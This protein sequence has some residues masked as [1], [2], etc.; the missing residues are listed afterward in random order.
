MNKTLLFKL[1]NYEECLFNTFVEKRKMFVN[2][3]SE[4]NFESLNEKQRSNFINDL[5]EI[6]HPIKNTIDSIDNFI[7]NQPSFINEQ[8]SKNNETMLNIVIHY[9]LFEGLFKTEIPD[10]DSELSEEVS[11]ESSEEIS[12]SSESSESV[13]SSESSES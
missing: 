11:S 6:I 7:L 2:K 8:S 10:E 13:L 9:F 5:Q 3:L 12:E 1:L 4:T